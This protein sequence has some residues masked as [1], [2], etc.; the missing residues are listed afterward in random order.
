VAAAY[1]QA[2][3]YVPGL[4]MVLV[5]GPRIDPARFAAHEGIDVLAYVPDLY[6]LLAACDVAVVQGGLTTAMELTATRTPFLY[7]RLRQHMEQS[8][9][10]HHRLQR[11]G[12]GRRMEIGDDIALAIAEEIGREVAYR[13][14]E[15]DGAATAAALIAELL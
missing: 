13:E 9:H 10:V 14:V 7:F 3:A 5:A 12:A 2:R 11:Y 1:D 4:R 8:F 15:R 6:R